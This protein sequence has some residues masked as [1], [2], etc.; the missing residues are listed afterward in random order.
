MSRFAFGDADGAMEQLQELLRRDANFTEARE[1]LDVVE[2]ARSGPAVTANPAEGFKAGAEAF[3]AGRRRRAIELWKVALAAEPSHRAYQL[4]VLL[5]TTLSDERRKGWTEEILALGSRR[6]AEGQSA[7]AYALLLVAQSAEQQAAPSPQGPAPYPASARN[8][9]D[10]DTV[11][12]SPPDESRESAPAQEP[13]TEDTR[14]HARA[15]AMSLRARR[16]A[17]P[18][19]KTPTIE[20]AP[21]GGSAPPFHSLG[22]GQG[23]QQPVVESEEAVLAGARE[24]ETRRRGSGE[25]RGPTGSRAPRSAARASPRVL[26]WGAAGVLI[27]LAAATVFLLTRGEGLPVEALEEAAGYLQ[28]GQYPR[29]ISA[30]TRILATHGEVAPAYLGRGRAY[31]VSGRLDEGLAD[32]SRALELE[33]NEPAVAEELADVL[34]ARGRF[35]EA[36][37]YYEQA[38]DAGELSA[39]SLYRLGSS[40]VQQQ[41]SDEA[42]PHLKSALDKNA[43]HAEARL[44]YANLLN[45]EGRHVDAEKVLRGTQIPSR[46][47]GDYYF[48]LALAFLEQGKLESAEEAT[49][50][51]QN[52]EPEAARPLSLLGEIYLKRKQYEAA[53]RELIRSLRINPR[54]P[55]AQIALGRTWLAIGKLRGDRSDLAKARQILASA[56]G[57]HEGE[58]LLTLGE[59][60]LAEGEVEK[61]IGLIEESLSQGAN[62]LSATLALAEARY[63]A[64]D[65]AGAAAE[66]QR[67]SGLSPSDPAIALSLGLVYSQL[68]DSA[69][70]T[71]QYLKAIQGIGMVD[72]AEGGSGPVVLPQPYVPLPSRADIN[73]LMRAAYREVLSEN[74]EESSA[75][76]LKML[77]ES[78]TF[79]VSGTN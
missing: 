52:Q 59:V 58:R 68:Q 14:P 40:L 25:S 45:A 50:E 44:L 8:G 17:P 24:T 12:L 53:R 21:P 37:R 10:D 70:A 78:T 54:E 71:E 32:L 30:Y 74:A 47:G 23:A 77:V 39:E 22:T 7:E 6:L 11:Y 31:I 60:T 28:Q 49:R 33:R 5:A 43:S 75:A 61:A 62:P 1:L 35:D 15:H 46:L 76:T 18:D 55:R 34:Y 66:L 19:D 26:L 4:V 57:V 20:S 38:L 2:G 16:P 67:A 72:P 3:A 65:L 69:R 48:E 64:K 51:L 9:L 63:V 79:V 42:L 36:V 73:R 27:V 56:Q 13:S 29:A 41:R